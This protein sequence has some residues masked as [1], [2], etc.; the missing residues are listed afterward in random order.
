MKNKKI[1]KKKGSNFR[2]RILT[3]TTII[4]IVLGF[5][6]IRL[7]YIV[8]RHGKEYKDMAENQWSAE[9][10]VKAP[11]GEILDRSGN[12][13]ATSIDVYRADLDLKAIEEYVEKKGMT[14]DKAAEKLASASG[15][16]I[17]EVKKKL[18]K[19]AED[20]SEILHSTLI[21]GID[22][23]VADK[24]KNTD[25]YGV[26]TSSS[27]KRYYPNNNFLSHVLGGVN[28]DSTGLNGVEL[29]YNSQLTGIAGY[30]IEEVDANQ[31]QLPNND[32][33][34]TNPI[35]GKSVTL[36]IDAQMQSIAESIA[37]EGYEK[38]KAKSASVIITDPNTGE[39]LAMANKP[40]FNP[41]KPE[42]QYEKFSGQNDFEK[43]QNMYRNIS[44]SDSF[45]PGSTFKNITMAT[46]LN[47]GLAKESDTFFCS[48]Y[49]KFGSTT[50]KCWKTDGHGLETLPQILINSCNVGFMELGQKIGKEKLNEYINRFGFG[51]ATNIDL[52][53]ESEGIVKSVETM[54]DMDLA[55]IAFGQTNSVNTMQLIS[56]INSIINGGKLIQ[57]HV[58]K[59][60]SHNDADGTK[61]IDEQFK[62][63]VKEN[64]VSEQ[65]TATL[66][67]YLE[68]TANQPGGIGSLLPKDRRVGAKTGTAQTVDTTTNGYSADNYISSAITMYPI[69]NPKVTIYMKVQN[70]STGTYYGG[71]VTAPLLKE[72]YTQLF[73]Y[74]DSSVYTQKYADKKT[75]ILPELRG[76]V[77]KEAKKI[78]A[79]KKLNLKVT[80][81]DNDKVTS[82]EP[83]PGSLVDEGANI[84]I[85]KENS[86]TDKDKVIMP[87]LKGKKLEEA[88]VILDSIGIKYSVNGT[89]TVVSQDIIADKIIDNDTKVKLDLK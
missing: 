47:E 64:M 26:V 48:G 53:G 37:Q 4:C 62:P 42:E 80:G 38:N 79:D 5:L 41:N 20:G 18:N 63:T 6:I 56:S 40:D 21:T 13:L 30:K 87:D 7:F 28:A 59:E 73:A 50:I 57:P 77:V 23:S 24:L 58:M 52:P 83:Y 88:K 89:G 33:K 3:V 32:A 46:A 17:D 66:R 75:V 71:Q 8:I 60:I 25:I 14:M 39:V 76:K 36:T 85:N 65:T 9:A 10:T 49:L 16:S 86:T 70:P 54:S 51:K 68:R 82:M 43:L 69:D 22:K 31:N 55:T 19:K 2:N 29:Q 12:V 27:P 45:E 78:I 61:I 74:M 72:L 35:P 67:D 84:S 15:L 11:R 34:Y 44:I 1:K 81:S